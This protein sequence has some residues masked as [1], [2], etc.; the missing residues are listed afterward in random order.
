MAWHMLPCIHCVAG[1]DVLLA[2]C[3]S[4]LGVGAADRPTTELQHPPPAV[5]DSVSCSSSQACLLLALLQLQACSK[6][7]QLQ[8]WIL[9][10][11]P[12]ACHLRFVAQGQKHAAQ[13]QSVPV[14]KAMSVRR[15]ASCG[16]AAQTAT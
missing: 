15:C 11:L 5:G 7:A 8:A 3:L 6:A 13:G 16:Q 1:M 12:P 4:K 14:P 10:V 9:E 2:L